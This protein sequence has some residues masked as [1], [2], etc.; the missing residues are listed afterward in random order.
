[1]RYDDSQRPQSDLGATPIPLQVSGSPLPAITLIRPMQSEGPE[2]F[3]VCTGAEGCTGEETGSNEGC[4]ACEE[5][6]ESV[7]GWLCCIHA[8]KATNRFGTYYG[9]VRDLGEFQE[10]YIEDPEA[11]LLRW[12]KYSGP[13][14][15]PT[16]NA[17]KPRGVITEDIFA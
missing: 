17:L 4:L 7:W 2:T 3:K 13:E 12:F 5:Q 10:A 14:W 15:E 16:Q 8:H 6:R 9:W 1:M 11:A